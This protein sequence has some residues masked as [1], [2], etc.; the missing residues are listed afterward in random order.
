MT[1]F[2]FNRGV[3][4]DGNALP[5]WEDNEE[6]DAYLRRTGYAMAK[7]SFG[8]EYGSQIEIYESEN[9]TSF[10][11]SVAPSGVN[12]FEVYLPDFPS[13][14]MFIRDHAAG[15]ASEAI[16]LAQQK[17]LNLQE[18]LFEAHHGHPADRICPQCDAAGWAE[19]IE[20]ENRKVRRGRI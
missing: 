15:F 20:R 5:E 10:Y 8:H 12:C 2:T 9:N 18:K 3:W 14:M 4:E 17:M 16:N 1:R 13:L 6:F 11:A 7:A 19:N